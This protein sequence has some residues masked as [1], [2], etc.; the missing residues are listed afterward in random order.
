MKFRKRQ[1]WQIFVF[2][3]NSLHCFVIYFI[4]SP[5]AVGIAIIT[6]LILFFS[7]SNYNFIPVGIEQQ[8]E[9]IATEKYDRDNN[10]FVSIRESFETQMASMQKYLSAHPEVAKAYGIIDLFGI[11]DDTYLGDFQA[12][13]ND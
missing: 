11:S 3:F 7:N 10:G 8:Y 6:N 4:L 1:V 12:N 2:I 13:P 5:G 9:F